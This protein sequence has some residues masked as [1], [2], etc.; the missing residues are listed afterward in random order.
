MHLQK[1]HHHRRQPAAAVAKQM[2]QIDVGIASAPAFAL[3]AAESEHVIMW[4]AVA[5]GSNRHELGHYT[6]FLL[7]AVKSV[8]VRKPA[9]LQ[10]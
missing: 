9:S 1:H 2:I 5:G 8:G 10:D 7:A 6:S 4:S 3:L